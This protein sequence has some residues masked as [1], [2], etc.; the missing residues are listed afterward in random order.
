M[1]IRNSFRRAFVGLVMLGCAQAGHTADMT[2]LYYR[3]QD[4]DTPSYLT[5]ILITPEFLRLDGGRDQADFVLLDRRTGELTN[6]LHE[7]KTNMR[8]RNRPL[9]EQARPPWH[10]DERIDEVHPG[11]QRIT[12]SV[13]GKVCSQTVA[14]EKLMPEAARALAEYKVALAWMQYQTYKN[15]PEELRQECDL[16]HYVWETDR[17]LGHGL[18]IE[19]RDY[20]GRTRQLERQ[21]RERLKPE[22]FKLPVGYTVVYATKE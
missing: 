3:D 8:I 13:H 15:T 4:P 9:P 10:A 12:L 5:R 11:T 21:D 22:L 20:S 2:V 17:P 19:E 18:P 6:V 7:T 16:V 14:A 1:K